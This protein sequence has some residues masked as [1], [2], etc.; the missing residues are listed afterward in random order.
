MTFRAVEVAFS[1]RDIG[2]KVIDQLSAD[3]YT[4][5][6]AMAREIVKNAYDAYQEL[7][8][9][10]GDT[11]RQIVITREKDRLTVADR[12]IGQDLTKIK[13]NLQISLPTKSDIDDA[14]GFRGLGSWAVFGAG[15][16]IVI[17]SSQL[18]S[19]VRYRLEIDVRRIYGILE[20]TVTLDEILNNRR[21]I[22]FSSEEC[23][24]DEHGTSLEII[25]DGPPDEINGHELNRLYEYTDPDDEK[26]R[27][28]LIRCCPLPYAAGDGETYKRIQAIHKRTKYARTEIILDGT[29]LE[30]RLP[31]DLS[32]YNEE[33]LSLGG[34]PV[35]IAWWVEDPRRTGDVDSLLDEKQHL[36]GG[37]GLQ[38]LK[39]N[40]PIGP[41]NIYSEEI[42]RNILN[43]YVG[44]IHIISPDIAPSAGGQELR[45]GSIGEM[46][47]DRLRQ[48]Y[49]SLE[50]RAELK[51]DRVS[52]ERKLKQ[53]I[54]GARQI[55]AGRLTGAEKQIELGRLAKTVQLIES[56][57]KRGRAKTAQESRLREAA[58]DPDVSRVR[59]EAIREM[60]N[61]D[62]Y[63]QFKKAATK[64]ETRS[65]ASRAKTEGKRGDN[66][67]IS[68]AQAFQARVGQTIPRLVDLGLSPEQVD[69]VMQ[70]IEEL[71]G[72]S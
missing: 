55:K 71:F 64:K 63:E 13:G 51:S 32:E 46:F 47:R 21:C 33:P 4:D 54:D 14:T 7:S 62:L 31:D 37:P 24:K 68:T 34:R 20:P 6:G 5:A 23:G 38:L 57:G 30:R 60:K 3:I 66:S 1:L 18:R 10:D 48:F 44:E 72:A 42:R 26:F 41:K 28:F 52:F 50:E 59:R 53:A 8:E 49:K 12:G 35:A 29:P 25:C 22:K 16:R 56:S 70:I 58:K 11:K 2:S 15:S 39:Y 45:G 36:L 65:E 9:D 40:V 61:A 67:N 19:G 17:T 69:G 43:W 27:E